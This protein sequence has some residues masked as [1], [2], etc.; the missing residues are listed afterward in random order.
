MRST[1][2]RCLGNIVGGHSVVG[3]LLMGLGANGSLGM[4]AGSLYSTKSDMLKVGLIP[5][6]DGNSST[7]TFGLIFLKIL[8]GPAPRACNFFMILGG[9]RLGVGLI[10]TYSPSKNYLFY[11]CWSARCL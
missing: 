5:R 11:L 1:L 7:S 6:S 8:K 2:S 3:S 9:N 10:M 4:N